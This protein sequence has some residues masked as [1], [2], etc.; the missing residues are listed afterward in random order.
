[1]GIQSAYEILTRPQPAE[2]DQL[3]I[4]AAQRCNKR[5]GRPNQPNEGVASYMLAV[6]IRWG[7]VGSDNL[8]SMQRKAYGKL[9]ADI[10]DV[11]ALMVQENI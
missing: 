9:I 2:R 10:V 7:Y 3:V 11:W 4:F 5:Y 6:L 1:M 8:K